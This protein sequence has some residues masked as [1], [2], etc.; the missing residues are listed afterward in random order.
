MKHLRTAV[1]GILAA[2]V[3]IILVRAAI[4]LKAQRDEADAALADCYL[5]NVELYRMLADCRDPY[6][7][8]VDSLTG[9]E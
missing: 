4:D 6:K 5:Q 9:G 1:I 2:V 3:I 7:E 8:I